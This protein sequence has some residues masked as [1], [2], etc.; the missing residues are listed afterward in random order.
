[1]ATNIV[2]ATEDQ[3][4]P[5]LF[6][7]IPL[8]TLV[9]DT[10]ADFDIYV[11]LKG[12]EFPV[13]FRSKS[14]PISTE[15]LHRL[16]DNKH[17]CILIPTS[18][19]K[20]YALYLEKHLETVLTDETVPVV[21]RTQLLYTTAHTMVENILANPEST[22]MMKSSKDLVASTAAF[23]KREKSAFEHLV[24]LV[25]YDYYTYTHSVNVFVYSF[26]LA[27]RAGIADEKTLLEFGEGTLLHDIGKCTIDPKILRAKGKLTDEQWKQMQKH[28]VTGF[29]ILRDHAMFSDLALEITRHHHEKLRGGGYPDNLTAK[30]I[31]PLVRVSTIADI[32]DALTTRRSYKEPMSSYRAL[33]LMNDEMALDLDTDLFKTFVELMG[34]PQG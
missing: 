25:S 15:V 27:S 6:R 16:G 34:N 31:D 30:Q 5:S 33:K 29:D 26:S 17:E 10:I 21:E 13:L 22:D 3:S 9:A 12:V 20:E 28:P 24:G 18:Q 8:A 1:M 19:G 32:F 11:Q 23:L 2:V 7:P 4:L 14:L